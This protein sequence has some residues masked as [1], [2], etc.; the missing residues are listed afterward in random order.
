MHVGENILD[1]NKNRWNPLD[2]MNL[3]YLSDNRKIKED[4]VYWT[5]NKD[6]IIETGFY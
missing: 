5:R 1:R 3:A 4:V 2:R 6:D